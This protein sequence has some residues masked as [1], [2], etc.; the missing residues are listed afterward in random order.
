MSQLNFVKSYNENEMLDT[1]ILLF[2]WG[3]TRA[4]IKVKHCNYFSMY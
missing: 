2:L 1:R 4:I 3:K